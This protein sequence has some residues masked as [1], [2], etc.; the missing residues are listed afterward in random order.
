MH[1]HSD[2]ATDTRG[3]AFI[4]LLLLMLVVAA[5]VVLSWI[6]VVPRLITGSVGELTGFPARVG[7]LYAN[8]FTGT[9]EGRQFSLR[10]PEQWGG[11]TFVDFGR[12]SGRVKLTSLR[13][14]TV[15]FEELR[16][17]L[18]HLVVVIDPDGST[19]V[20]AL[21]ERFAMASPT[22]AV[23]LPHYATA[24]LFSGAESPSEILI[25]QLDLRIRTIEIRDRGTVPAGVIRDD[26]N[27]DHRYSDVRRYEQ[28]ITPQLLASL[29]KSPATLQ[30]LLRSGLLGGA[31]NTSG[32]GLQQLFERA[33]GAINSLLQGLEQTGKP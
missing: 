20:E 3:G 15:V 9:F 16:L 24:G 25:E 7:Q 11:D 14:R 31:G 27:Y 18:D 8:P 22:D 10:N 2:R 13:S 5:V 29:A 4:S 1:R 19:N 32:S 26:I 23:E 33:G 6:L 30:V 21:G 12:V 28:I 17:D